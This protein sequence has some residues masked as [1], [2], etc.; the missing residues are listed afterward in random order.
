[1]LRADDLSLVLPSPL[2]V[3]SPG[4][5]AYDQILLQMVWRILHDQ[6]EGD[7]DHVREEALL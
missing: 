7:L 5:H 3:L 6:A 4:C 1:M 2:L